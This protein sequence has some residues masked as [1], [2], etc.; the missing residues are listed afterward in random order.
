MCDFNVRPD[1][2]Y[3]KRFCD[4]F[5]L[6]NLI[7]EHTCFKNP[8]NPSCIDLIL[9]NRPSNFQNACCAI[10]TS[11]SDFYKMTFAAMRKHFQKYKPR[12]IKS[13]DYN[14]F[15]NNAFREDLLSELLNFN[16]NI[17]DKGFAELF[18]T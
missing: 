14:H 10:E 18:E 2:T 13:R 7:K 11:L 3:I 12:L 8:E 4:N 1:N 6:T 17:S 15:Q 5:D 16:I 9:I